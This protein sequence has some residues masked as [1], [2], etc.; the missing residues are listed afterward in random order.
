MLA[1]VGERD[2]VQLRAPCSAPSGRSRSAAAGA[3]SGSRRAGRRRSAPPAA[4]EPVASSD[5]AASRA[6]APAST[7]PSS[8]TTSTGS[9][10][11]RGVRRHPVQLCGIQ[12]AHTSASAARAA[13]PPPRRRPGNVSPPAQHPRSRSHDAPWT[14]VGRARSPVTERGRR[15]RRRRRAGSGSSGRSALA[16]YIVGVM[17]RTSFGV[18]GLDAAQRFDAGPAALLR[19]RRAAAPGLRGPAGAR[20]PAARPVRRPDA[21]RRRER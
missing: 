9:A 13:R 6:A 15:P 19:V 17:H 14:S 16:A 5:S 4:R 12:H 21:G 10:S 18:A 3:G 11:C 7:N 1:G 2:D 20:R 8:T